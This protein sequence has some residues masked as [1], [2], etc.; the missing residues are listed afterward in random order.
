MKP[1]NL[2]P[3]WNVVTVMWADAQRQ[4][5]MRVALQNAGVRFSGDDSMEP[6]PPYV[7]IR[8]PANDGMMV[9]QGPAVAVPA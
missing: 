1:F 8:M 6:L 4:G 2:P 5:G 3:D 7:V 9:L